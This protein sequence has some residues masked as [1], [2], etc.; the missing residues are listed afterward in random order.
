M[1]ARV[2]EGLATVLA[3]RRLAAILAVTVVFNI[4]GWPFTSMIPVIGRDQ[5]A[6]GPEGVGLLTSIDGVGAFVGALVLA[7]RLAPRFHAASYVGGV[8]LYQ[9]GIIA[10]ALVPGVVPAS[11]ALLLTGL[12][13][14]AFATLQ[15]T[16]VYLA[17]PIE[18]RSR[19][20]G[21]LSVCIG[22]GTA[23]LPVAG[24]ALRTGSARPRRRPSPAPWGWRC[25]LRCDRCGGRSNRVRSPVRDDGWGLNLYLTILKYHLSSFLYR[26]GLSSCLIW[27]PPRKTVHATAVSRPIHRQALP[28]E[29]RIIGGW[30]EVDAALFDDGGGVAP[31][32]PLELLPLPWRGWAADTAAG[33]GA[34]PPMW[35]SPCWRRCP[36]SAAPASSPASRPRGRSHWCCG[37][38]WSA[39]RRA[40]SRRRW[41]RCGLARPARRGAQES[42]AE[43]KPPLVLPTP[44]PPYARRR[45][46]RPRRG[47]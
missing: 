5:L 31:A 13:G 15:A 24:L 35:Y 28:A 41:R 20:M 30:P 34:P 42:D 1:L 37:W 45:A 2:R 25:C 43:G 21:V 44:A 46:G 17:A 4:F 8:A 29:P 14:G 3:N 10:F 40:A 32:F 38:R 12:A 27:I 47:A 16:L 7:W 33:A 9:A 26:K 6:L 36:A 19:I 39:A 23:R 22:T 18:M 11:A